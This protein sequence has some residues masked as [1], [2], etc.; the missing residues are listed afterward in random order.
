MGHAHS[1]D[2]RK[3]VAGQICLAIE[4]QQVVEALRRMRY[5]QEFSECIRRVAAL[6]PAS[7]LG[8]KQI[9]FRVFVEARNAVGV[10]LVGIKR[11]I[12][13]EVLAVGGSWYRPASPQHKVSPQKPRDAFKRRA[14]V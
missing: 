1:I 12:A 14:L 9:T 13:Q 4:V 5:R 7:D 6:K 3:N 8:R 2:L 10:S 11:D